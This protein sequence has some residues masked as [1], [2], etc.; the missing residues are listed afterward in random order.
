MHNICEL[1]LIRLGRPFEM[2]CSAEVDERGPEL[3]QE[4]AKGGLCE[5]HRA[6]MYALFLL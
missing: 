4:W 2:N 5:S 3:C 1:K 6:T